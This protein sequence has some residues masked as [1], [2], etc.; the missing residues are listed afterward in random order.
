MSKSARA[1]RREQSRIGVNL[2]L[3][4]TVYALIRAKAARANVTARRYLTEVVQA[5]AYSTTTERGPTHD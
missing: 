1:R 5:A 3:D 4:R 2:S